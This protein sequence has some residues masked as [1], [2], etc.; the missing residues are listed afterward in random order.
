[1][2]PRHYYPPGPCVAY[3]SRGNPCPNR[4]ERMPLCADH[5]Y[6][7]G[8]DG[9]CWTEKDSHSQ[10]VRDLASAWERGYDRGYERPAEERHEASVRADI[11]AG[12][13][14]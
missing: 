11:D 8:H 2:T 5:L 9:D 4:A 1:M 12:L 10:H 13:A 6:V 14:F 7:W 3:D